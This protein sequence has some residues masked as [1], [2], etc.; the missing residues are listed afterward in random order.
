MQPRIKS[1]ASDSTESDLSAASIVDDD[2]L[3][4]DDILSSLE[5]A[6]SHRSNHANF[7]IEDEDEENDGNITSFFF[8]QFSL[9]LKCRA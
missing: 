8:V 3:S 2:R 9:L 6:S 7:G 1:F 5:T 4:G